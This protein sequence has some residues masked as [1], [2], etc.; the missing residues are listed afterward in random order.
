MA[1]Y[2]LKCEFASDLL[3]KKYIGSLFRAWTV[4][5]NVVPA[6]ISNGTVFVKWVDSEGQEYRLYCPSDTAIYVGMGSGARMIYSSNGWVENWADEAFSHKIGMEITYINTDIDWN[7]W[8]CIGGTQT[9]SFTIPN[10]IGTYRIDF[11]L[12]DK[13]IHSGIVEVSP[14]LN[15]YLITANMTNGSKLTS[16]IETQYAIDFP[17]VSIYKDLEDNDVKIYVNNSNNE[18]PLEIAITTEYW[19]GV[20]N[21]TEAGSSFNYILPSGV[22]SRRTVNYWKDSDKKIQIM[23]VY[24]TVKDQ[25]HYQSLTESFTTGNMEEETSS[26]TTIMS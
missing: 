14:K 18:I 22:E 16:V 2:Q 7:N 10:S 4:D 3:D 24:I 1:E 12:D 9:K 15:R 8:L 21:L 26:T 6:H 25:S 11:E 23:R 20:N 19:D 13:T 5:F 17:Y